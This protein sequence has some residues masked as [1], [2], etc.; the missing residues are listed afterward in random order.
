MLVLLLVQHLGSR[1]LLQSQIV[2]IPDQSSFL[3]KL[4]TYPSPNWTLT[5]TSH[6]LQNVGVG[7][8]FPRRWR[9]CK[10][11]TTPRSP[12][13]SYFPLVT[14][15]PVSLTPIISL[16]PSLSYVPLP[17][18]LSPTHPRQLFP[19]D[20]RSY[21]AC[22]TRMQPAFVCTSTIR[23]VIKENWEQAECLL[24]YQRVEQLKEMVKPRGRSR[25][26]ERSN[27]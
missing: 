19:G 1:H 16:I 5:L 10:S 13:L 9:V 6:L 15:P 20:Q 18:T 23:Q 3:G 27:F 24:T 26:L 25:P 21:Y 7:G 4:P 17:F 14:W 8:Q 12:F 2:K 11:L 22:A